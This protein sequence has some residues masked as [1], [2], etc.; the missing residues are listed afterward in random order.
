MLGER[1]AHLS[2]NT[3]GTGA[4]NRLLHRFISGLTS[5]GPHFHAAQDLAAVSSDTPWQRTPTQ[6][7]V[8]TLVG[9]QQQAGLPPA[10]I[11]GEDPL[12]RQHYGL[13][14]KVTTVVSSAVTAREKNA[15]APSKTQSNLAPPGSYSEPRRLGDFASFIIED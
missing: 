2:P 15:E 8:S 14:T 13:P 7:E 1:V 4:K 12:Q 10:L 6:A 9:H 5:F 3:L 11:Q